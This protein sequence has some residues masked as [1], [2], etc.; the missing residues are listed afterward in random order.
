MKKTILA[1]CLFISLQSHSQIDEGL[2]NQY[3]K[4]VFE[5]DYVERKPIFPY[6]A[7]SLRNFYLSH[8]TVGDSLLARCIANGDT[9]KYIRVKFEFVIDE[10]GNT[11][12]QSSF[13]LLPHVTSQAVATRK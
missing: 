2:G 1:I 7:D 10:N 5:Y 11:Y 8:F 13:T 6:T 9:A 12:D 3:Y 4:R